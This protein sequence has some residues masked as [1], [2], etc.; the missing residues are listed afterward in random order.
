MNPEDGEPVTRLLHEEATCEGVEV[1][2]RDLDATKLA[3]MIVLV[4]AAFVLI[5]AV[6]YM[7][8]PDPF[9]ISCDE[10]ERRA[11]SRSQKEFSEHIDRCTWGWP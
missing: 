5:A 4:S 2:E 7:T 1:R 11:E 8:F 10:L 6:V 9:P 3:A